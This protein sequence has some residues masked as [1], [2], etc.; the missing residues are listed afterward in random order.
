MRSACLLMLGLALA[1]PAAGS[2]ALPGLDLGRLIGGEVA[3]GFAVADGP[4]PFRFPED[5]GA[6]PDFRTEWWYLVTHLED[7]N[8]RPFS[9]QF[10]LFR[11]ALA[12]PRVEGVEPASRW[13][14]RQVWMAHVALSGPDGRH[15]ASERFARAELGLAG[16]RAEPFAAW[17]E[18]WR[19]AAA[20]AAAL[21]P[22]ALNARV[23][24][25]ERPFRLN[26]EFDEA[27]G[28]I[29]QGDRG[30]SPKSAREGNASYYYS[31]TRMRARGS[32][33]L[34]GAEV[35]VSGLA[36]LD[37]EWS[38]SV[39]DPGQTGWDW[40]AL[41]LDDGRDLKVF[42]IRRDDGSIDAA[43]AGTLVEADGRAKA[44]D[45]DD[46]S[47][48]PLETWADGDGGHWP[49]AWR[50]EVPMAGVAGRVVA[51]HPDQLNRLSVRYWEGQVCLDGPVAG[52][53]FLEMTGYGAPAAD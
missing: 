11:Q 34:D 21:F 13:R 38:S 37:R 1:W 24:D 53:G 45:R 44:L 20:P 30:Y 49:V 46:F 32:I 6:H 17:L 29:L 31:F 18:D 2:E 16:V 40:F 9:A 50:L 42:Q 5:H 15:Q 52:C 7:A 8:G 27:R 26:L 10:T 22:L 47:L 3:T 4:R 51:R 23:D 19:L 35:E 43:S 25:V 28:P 14:T 33:E 36:W 39:L 41:H 12:P 48:E